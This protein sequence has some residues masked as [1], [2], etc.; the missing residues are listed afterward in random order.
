M[1]SSGIWRRVDFVWTEVSEEI[2]ASIFRVEKSEREGGEPAWAG[3]CSWILH[4]HPCENLKTY[5][6]SQIV[7]CV[8]AE[9]EILIGAL[10][11]CE[12]AQK[13]RKREKKLDPITGSCQCSVYSERISFRL[14]PQYIDLRIIE[15]SLSFMGINEN[16]KLFENPAPLTNQ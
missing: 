9:G 2:I 6:S 15:Y 1:Q 13:E 7:S 16:L 3:G 8:Q 10:Q 11:N 12:R 14:L 5:N 4:S